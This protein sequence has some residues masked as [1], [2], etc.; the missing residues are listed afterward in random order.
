MGNLNDCND[1]SNNH[2][3]LQCESHSCAAHPAC[4]AAGLAGDFCPTSDG[5]TLGCRS[6]HSEV[7]ETSGGVISFVSLL[8]LSRESFFLLFQLKFCGT[9][10]SSS[11]CSVSAIWCPE[12]F[13]V[14]V[15]L[16]RYFHD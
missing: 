16:F 5:V 7:M 1:L 3:K 12:S 4:A 2:G 6:S 9:S 13:S 8:I 10:Q 11:C 14:W 15:R